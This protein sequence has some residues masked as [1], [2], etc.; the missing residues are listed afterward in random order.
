[1]SEH[2]RRGFLKALGLSGLGLAGCGRTD[3]PEAQPASEAPPVGT[4]TAPATSP[5][6][7]IA[8]DEAV[9]SEE[10]E[11]DGER[12]E[13][14]L[15]RAMVALSGVTEAAEAWRRHFRADDTVAM[16]INALAGPELSTHRELCYAIADGLVSGGVSQ[17]NVIIFDRDSRELEAL[18]FEVNAAGRGVKVIG[19]DLTGYDRAPTVVKSVGSCFSTI[20]S[21]MATALV[22]VPV[23]KDHDLA[24]LSGALKNHF[25]SIHNPN[26]LHTDG[27]YP[28]V[29]DLNCA[30]MIRGKQ[31]LVVY[32]AL[33]V[34]YEGGPAYNPAATVR[35]GAILVSTD[36]VAAD[37]AALEILDGLRRT[38]GLKPLAEEERAPRYIQLAAEYGLGQAEPEKTEV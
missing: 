22:N 33:N 38:H 30:D 6:V 8:R 37:A 32:D 24:G 4:T 29:A 17:D 25:G 15:A 35:Y 9:I 31:R 3:G 27:C 11:V 16:K 7:V 14:M 34:C 26:K 36:P 13:Q 2:T 19:T 10:G 23:L 1:M 18:G 21:Q 12:L 20:V 5:R 28:Y